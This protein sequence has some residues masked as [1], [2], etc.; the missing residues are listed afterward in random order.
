[1]KLFD[2]CNVINRLFKWDISNEISVD[3]EENVPSG[4][5][6]ET[7]HGI[8]KLRFPQQGEYKLFVINSHTKRLLSTVHKIKVNL[9]GD[10]IVSHD[11]NF[12]SKFD[13]NDVEETPPRPLVR[14]SGVLAVSGLHPV[15]IPHSMLPP[16]SSNGGSFSISFWIRL[17]ESAT[18][19]FRALFYKGDGVSPNR[20]PSAWLIPTSNRVALRSTTKDTPDLGADTTISIPNDQWTHLCFIFHNQTKKNATNGYKIVAYVNGKLDISIGYSTEVIPN[21]SSLQLFHDIS[22][23][24]PRSF[25]ADFVVWDSPLT[26]SH[27]KNLA[28]TVASSFN[29]W[30]KPVDIALDLMKNTLNIPVDPNHKE[31]EFDNGMHTNTDNELETSLIMISEDKHYSYDL[32]LKSLPE[33]A[34]TPLST[35]PLNYLLQE[36]QSAVES[37]ASPS[38]RLDLY[39]EAASLGKIF[40]H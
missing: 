40:C 25:V 19:K 7:F 32:L 24:G 2:T 14:H 3:F 33:P 20:T 13:S 18:G 35:A 8:F 22:H 10:N 11:L 38:I 23:S 16:V 30:T 21:N 4:G 31:K 29:R 17:L 1:M 9:C 15:I 26:S 5:A 28:S 27:V 36:I 37:C 6:S 34:I 12:R 39:A